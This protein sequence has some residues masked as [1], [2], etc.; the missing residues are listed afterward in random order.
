MANQKRDLKKKVASLSALGAGAFVFGAG[1][2]E[3][4][5]IYSGV[6]DSHVGFTSGNQSLISPGIG[7]SHASFAFWATS[8]SGSGSST[9]QIRAYG[10]GSLRIA[11]QAGLI[12]L[13]NL[14]A[15]WTAAQGADS[16]MLVGG[17]IWGTAPISGP[18]SS[19]STSFPSYYS[20][21][22]SFGHQSFNHLYSLF[23]FN[24]GGQTLYGWMQLSFAVSGQFGPNPSFGPELIVHDFAYDDSGAMISAGATTSSVPEPSTAASTGLAALALGAVGLRSWRKNRKAA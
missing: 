4:G 9:R 15:L 23:A 8:S 19:S 10:Y 3:A 6:L 12:Q 1:N 17:R 20:F 14:G 5:I 11:K 18:G 22:G 24:Q 7:A 16:S 2:A 21:A 13:F